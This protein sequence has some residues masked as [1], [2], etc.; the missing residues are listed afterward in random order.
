MDYTFLKLQNKRFAI[1]ILGSILPSRFSFVLAAM[2]TE[3][4]DGKSGED[5]VNT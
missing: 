3:V 5:A 2:I 4:E 1:H